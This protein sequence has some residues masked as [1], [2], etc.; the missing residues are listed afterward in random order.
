MATCFV[1]GDEL[2]PGSKVCAL[3]GTSVVTDAG[4]E[5]TASPTTG[6]SGSF[7]LPLDANAPADEGFI[8]GAPVPEQRI[9]PRCGKQYGPDYPDIFCEC[10][11]ELVAA[12]EAEPV[13]ATVAPG[14]PPPV[15]R[16]EVPRPPAGT[17]CLVLYGADRQPLQYF[18][19]G[20][21]VILIGRLDAVRGVFP[22]VDLAACLEPAMAR[23]ISRKH[24][25]VL[26]SRA[27][28]AFALR[29]LAGNTGTQIEQN[30][31]EP[32][33]D[34]PLAPGTR[35]LLGG[36]ARLKMEIIS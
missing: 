32:L 7:S 13:A 33:R 30:M 11:L 15:V 31:A 6:D 10:G 16:P 27:N 34:Y 14:V 18:P 9:C 19:L 1:C 2:K 22:D 23:K 35:V 21:D 5:V 29:P 24:A 36:V 25:L 3:C 4:T 17:R 20:K 8:Q 26:H 12:A 28:D